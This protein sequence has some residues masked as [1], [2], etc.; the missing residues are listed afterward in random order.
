MERKTNVPKKHK[1]LK[2]NIYEQVSIYNR[3][4]F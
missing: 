2:N 4:N 1:Q 3:K